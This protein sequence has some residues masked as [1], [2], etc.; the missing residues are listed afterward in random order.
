MIGGMSPAQIHASYPYLSMAQIHAA[1]AY[2]YDHQT[3]M[4]AQIT[5]ENE[6]VRALRGA[7]NQPSRAELEERF[8]QRRQGGTLPCPPLF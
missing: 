5:R 2:Y 6:E 4:D 7:S 3:E 8:K 1:L